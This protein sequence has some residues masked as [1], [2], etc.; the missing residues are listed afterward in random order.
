MTKGNL[1]FAWLAH[2][3]LLYY[4]LYFSIL[5]VKIKMVLVQRENCGTITD[6]LKIWHHYNYS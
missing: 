2:H 4:L 1:Y 3:C 6:I 5:K